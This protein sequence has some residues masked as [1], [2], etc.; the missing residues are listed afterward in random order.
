[1]ED[2]RFSTNWNNK[3]DCKAFTT[4]RLPNQKY[5][6]GKE[7][8]IIFKGVSKG[9]G[10]IHSIKTIGFQ[11]INEYIARIDTGYSAKEC[12]DILRKMYPNV[13]FAVQKLAFIL[14]VKR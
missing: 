9:T 4:L 11:D 1:M 14:I 7:F 3:L 8:N 12:K 2:F 5:T 13:D 10:I 6:I